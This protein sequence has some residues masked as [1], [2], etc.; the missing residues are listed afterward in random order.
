MQQYQFNELYNRM[1][2]LEKCQNVTKYAEETT[3]E[4]D[5]K[6]SMDAK[7]IGKFTTQ[8]V[9]SVMAHKTKQYEKYIKNLKKGGKDRVSGESAKDGTRGGGRA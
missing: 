2:K 9:A 8:Q 7:L 6:M 5:R 3:M 1:S 4:L